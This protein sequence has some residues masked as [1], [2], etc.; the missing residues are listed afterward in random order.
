MLS[1][2]EPGTYRALGKASPPPSSS[3]GPSPHPAPT[4]WLERPQS[5][6]VRRTAGVGD[7]VLSMWQRHGQDDAAYL[8]RIARVLEAGRDAPAVARMDTWW[9]LPDSTAGWGGAPAAS[10]NQPRESR[11]P[12]RR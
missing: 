7:V 4:S 12:T 8:L 6:P 5:V 1:V 2:P 11:A 10:R 9:T 3:S